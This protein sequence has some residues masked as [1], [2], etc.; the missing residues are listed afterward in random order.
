MSLKFLFQHLPDKVKVN[1]V[2]GKSGSFAEGLYLI[3]II[4]FKSL[5]Q[6]F[7]RDELFLWLRLQYTFLHQMQ[8]S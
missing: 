3:S 7:V 2:K 6:L 4:Q 1:I 8:Y 5:K